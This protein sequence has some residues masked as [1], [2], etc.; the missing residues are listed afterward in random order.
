MR[1]GGYQP[2]ELG[3]NESCTP[4]DRLEHGSDISVHAGNPPSP[5]QDT[6]NREEIVSPD[7]FVFDQ[8]PGALD[9]TRGLDS[10]PMVYGHK[11]D[12]DLWCVHVVVRGGVAL[13]LTADRARILAGELMAYAELTDE[14]N[15]R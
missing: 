6:M 2:D 12:G 8:R 3:T 13:A 11:S 4:A 5:Q 14:G 10:L 1:Q 15:A 7:A 9:A